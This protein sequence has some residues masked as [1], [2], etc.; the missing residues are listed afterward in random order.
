[1]LKPASIRRAGPRRHIV[2]F[3]Q[4][5]AGRVRLKIKGTGGDQVIV[6]HAEIPTAG[7]V[8]DRRNLRV[9]PGRGSLCPRPRDRRA[10]PATGLHLS[11]LFATPRSKG[12][13]C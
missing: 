11:G 9:R 13:R 5:F 1:M 10:N 12:R 2:D 6:R 7:G 3:G 4:N 8:L